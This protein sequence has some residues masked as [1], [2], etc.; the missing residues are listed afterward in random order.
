LGS[1]LEGSVITKDTHNLLVSCVNVS[2]FATPYLVAFAPRAA[3][4]LERR[5]QELR[6]ESTESKSAHGA[7]DVIIVGYGPAGQAV[8][9]FLAQREVKTLVVDVNP[10]AQLRAERIGLTG[11]IGDA[12]QVDVLEHAHVE[13]ARFVVITLPA[14]SAALIVLEHV[15]ALSPHA[16]VIVRTRYQMHQAEFEAAGAH[17]VVDDEVEAGRRLQAHMRAEL[18]RTPSFKPPRLRHAAPPDDA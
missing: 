11:L 13:G 2:L 16:V 15:R 17:V 18:A 1:A 9:R 4:W 14:R 8:G 6:D 3:A 12:T 7:A 5:R 10:A